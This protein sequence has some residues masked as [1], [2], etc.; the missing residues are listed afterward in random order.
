VAA[1][2]A[3]AGGATVALGA[4]VLL[5]AAHALQGPALLG[6]GSP[7]AEALALV[8]AGSGYGLWAAGRPPRRS[9]GPPPAN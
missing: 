4:L 8:A 2:V 1:V 9:D 7:I 5:A 3:T 6:G